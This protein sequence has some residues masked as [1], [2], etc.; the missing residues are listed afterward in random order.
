[1]FD[2]VGTK[3]APHSGAM[4]DYAAEKPPTLERQWFL[5]ALGFLI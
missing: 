1:V 2:N 5:T 4:V 3:T